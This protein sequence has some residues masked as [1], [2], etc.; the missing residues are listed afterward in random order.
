MTRK[1]VI[2][3]EPVVGQKARV[4]SLKHPATRKECLFLDRPDGIY[5]FTTVGHKNDA[6]L[7]GSNFVIG[8]DDASIAVATPINPVYFVLAVLY[9]NKSRFLDISYLEDLLGDPPFGASKFAHLL[10]SLCEENTGMF[11]YSE[12]KTLAYLQGKKHMLVEKFFSL[13]KSIRDLAI[14]PIQD[15]VSP[16]DE[17]IDPTILRLAQDKL[18]VELISTYLLPEL[19]DLL[20]NSTDY[21]LLD[22]RIEECAL[23]E[24]RAIERQQ[25]MLNA[26]TAG[27]RTA[28][29]DSKPKGPAAKK[30]RTETKPKNNNSIMAM[31]KKK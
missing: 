7:L 24:A 3:P 1:L 21:S 8:N 31:F 2:V 11:K 27:K 4:Y 10:P 30:T 13:P 28:S 25:D 15:S 18:A 12:S 16:L 5:E 26:L 29:G 19:R 22:Q 14:N 23:N 9:E 6:I 20:Y 17:L